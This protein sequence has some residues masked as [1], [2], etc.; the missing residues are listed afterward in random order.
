MNKEFILQNKIE[1]YI[2]IGVLCLG[3]ILIA[4]FGFTKNQ[5]NDG[6]PNLLMGIVGYIT[7]TTGLILGI[8]LI[9]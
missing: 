7:T 6:L 5:K 3:I 4:L 2:F 1:I 8:S 9:E